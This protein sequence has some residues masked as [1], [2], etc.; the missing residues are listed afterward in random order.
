VDAWNALGICHEE[1]RI[2]MDRHVGVDVHT[3]GCRFAVLDSAG[4]LLRR[5]V[6]ETNVRA[7]VGYV[8]QVPA[9]VPRE[10]LVEQDRASDVLVISLN[11]KEQPLVSYETVL[12]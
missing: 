1:R 5:D 2:V 7:L 11:R 10:L 8:K 4:K 9:D 3:S 6:V 12:H